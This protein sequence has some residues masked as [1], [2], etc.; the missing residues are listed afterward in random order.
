MDPITIIVS[1]LAAGAAAGLKPKAEQAVKDAY[2]GLKALILH[3]YGKL[4]VDALEQKP[5]SK[6]KRSSVAEDLS[7]AGA[8]QDT[9]LLDQ[10]MALL[11]A[12]KV[13]AQAEAAKLN[14][15]LEDIE[16]AYF[17]LKSSAAE[18]DVNIGLKKG[19]FTDGIDMEG[20]TAGTP[21]KK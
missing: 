19:K 2:N 3:K 1:A 13:H 8:A 9:E 14:I 6:A 17:K 20:L 18:G 12:I 15:N 5:E 11:D 21:G 4:S 10:A 16:S 7:D